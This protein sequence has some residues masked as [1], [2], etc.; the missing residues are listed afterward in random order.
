[1][2]CIVTTVESFEQRVSRINARKSGAIHI[3]TY[4]SA[5]I[6][7]QPNAIDRFL[8]VNPDTQ[9]EISTGVDSLSRLMDDET[10]DLA[11]CEEHIVSGNYQWRCCLR[12]KCVRCFVQMIH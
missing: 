12:T 5:L 11:I 10:L 9:F 6:C 1:M 3:G 8:S 2:E 4:N 7:L